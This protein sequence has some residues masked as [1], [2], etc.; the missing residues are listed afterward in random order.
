[1]I[2][3]QELIDMILE[4]HD[5]DDLIIRLSYSEEDGLEYASFGPVRQPD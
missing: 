2:T 3:V 5:P 4:N 1:M